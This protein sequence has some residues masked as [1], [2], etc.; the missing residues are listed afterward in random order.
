MPHDALWSAVEH[1]LAAAEFFF[2][3]MSQDIAPPYLNR[4][5]LAAITFGTGAIVGHPWQEKFYHH[6]DAFLAMAR[7]VP[8]I[9]RCCFGVDS[10]RR[11]SAWLTGLNSAELTR[12]RAFQQQFGPLG[13]AFVN[14]P[15]SG[16]RNITLHRTGVSPVTVHVVGRWGT[17]IG[18][19]LTA[20][21]QS[22][23]LSVAA[24]NDP[25]LQW[26][27][28]EPAQPVRPL[29]ADFSLRLP[30]GCSPSTVELFPE[31]QRFLNAAKALTADAR[32]I[33][34][35]VHG[36]HPLTPPPG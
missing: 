4:P 20:I 23:I 11:M 2:R 12:R 30:A 25:A 24:G 18:D 8:E 26:A 6:F 1:R 31:C 36:S 14:L 34:E 33:A 15:L 35:T 19:P 21:P 32:A 22:E 10:D 28:T 29:A 27:A 16:A 5:E 17:Y 13:S 9:I 7:S 3:E